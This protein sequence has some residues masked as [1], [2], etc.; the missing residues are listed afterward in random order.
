VSGICIQ[1][2]IIDSVFTNVFF[3]IFVSFKNGLAYFYS[4][5]TFCIYAGNRSDYSTRD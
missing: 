3:L 2:H 5:R 1:R 4:F